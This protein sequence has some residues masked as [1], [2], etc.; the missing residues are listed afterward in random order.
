MG[1]QILLLGNPGG[2]PYRILMRGPR[3]R[4]GEFDNFF[5]QQEIKKRR[6]VE[7]GGGK[8]R[9]KVGRRLRQLRRLL[10]G[11]GGLRLVGVV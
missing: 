7:R 11:M 3:V 1:R 10:P 5:L 6:L 8:G 4:W 2:L 9:R